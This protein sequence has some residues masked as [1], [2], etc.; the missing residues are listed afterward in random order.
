VAVLVDRVTVSPFYSN[1]YLVACP[2]TRKAIIV[3]PGDEAPRILAMVTAHQ[4]TVATIVATHGHLDHVL[5]VSAIKKATAAT[6]LIPEGEWALAQQAHG[7]APFY[8]WANTDPVPTPDGFLRDGDTLT[9]GN[10][11]IQTLAVPGHSPD[12]IAL[13]L[14]E[15]PGHL[16]C[17]DVLFA[18][19]VGRT[20]LPGGDLAT[21]CR[22]LRRLLSL[23]DETIVYPG[24][25]PTTTIGHERQTN[26]FLREVI[27]Q[28]GDDL[29]G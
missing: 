28:W 18:G 2:T 14:P 21:L 3:D 22:S 13:Y 27:D 11:I 23:P 4:V 15:S 25:G 6:F 7:L 5:A 16:F 26:P 17:G 8:G 24:H 9:V 10:L 19:S 1:C 12:H 20:D 29:N